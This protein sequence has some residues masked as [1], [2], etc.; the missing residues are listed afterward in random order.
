M[1]SPL[2]RRPARERGLDLRTVRGSG[3]GG[4]VLRR[5]VEAPRDPSPVH[6]GRA[7][8]VP[9]SPSSP[10]EHRVPEAVR[11]PLRGARRTIADKLARS[12][13]EIPDATTWVD[14]DATRLLDV[15][16]HLAAPDEE[17]ISLLALLARV[18]VAASPGTRSST[19]PWTPTAR[20]SS[21]S[22]PAPGRGH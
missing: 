18:C 22:P 19:P 5:D 11:V 16:R 6:T 9:A 2:V 15:K 12:R 7:E 4:L 14:V 1:I 17:R 3:P 21:A 20:R 13:R 10:Q 8:D